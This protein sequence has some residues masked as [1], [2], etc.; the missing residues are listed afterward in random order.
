MSLGSWLDFRPPA[1]GCM[2]LPFWLNFLICC[3]SVYGPQLSVPTWDFGKRE[4]H[5]T[6]HLF[7]TLQWFA[8]TKP[9]GSCSTAGSILHSLAP[10]LLCD[11]FPPEFPIANHPGLL[12]P[13]TTAHLHAFAHTV[14]LASWNSSLSSS[15]ASLAPRSSALIAVAGFHGGLST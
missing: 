10:A 2:S 13:S 9:F 12:K 5:C 3:Q 7:E 8:T 14:P 15:L 6:A 1:Q 4:S 11:L